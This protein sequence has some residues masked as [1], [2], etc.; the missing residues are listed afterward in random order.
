M[1][2]HH[3]GVRP[4]DLV[5]HAG[6]VSAIADRVTAAARA[7]AAIRPGAEAYGKLCVLVPVMLNALQDTLVD[8]ITAAADSVRD[9]GDR[10]RTTAQAYAAADERSAS[11]LGRT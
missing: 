7:G 4:E 9:T 2:D 1:T 10:L 3:F 5:A 11:K 6:H 8:G